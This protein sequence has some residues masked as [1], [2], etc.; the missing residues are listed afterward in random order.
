MRYVLVAESKGARG[1]PRRRHREVV[2]ITEDKV[3]ADRD[4][5]DLTNK[6]KRFYVMTY[7]QVKEVAPD[8]L[9]T[10]ENLPH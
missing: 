8:E 1:A 7:D 4:A 6:S 2:Y 3:R 10:Y 9:S 5:S